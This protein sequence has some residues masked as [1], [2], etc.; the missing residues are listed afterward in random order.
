MVSE[1]LGT[2]YSKCRQGIRDQVEAKV[3]QICEVGCCIESCV[4]LG[5]VQAERDCGDFS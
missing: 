1:V 5:N 4:D 3:Q 2:R